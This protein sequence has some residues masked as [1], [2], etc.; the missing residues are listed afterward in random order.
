VIQANRYRLACSPALLAPGENLLPDLK[1]LRGAP[2]KLEQTKVLAMRSP[3]RRSARPAS[4]QSR[5]GKG[6]IQDRIQLAITD[7]IAD[8]RLNH[9]AKMNALDPAMF[10]AIAG[11]D[12]Q[13][14]DDRGLR[15]VVLSGEGR[16]FW[17][18]LISRESPRS[19]GA[20]ASCRS[21]ISPRAPTVSAIGPHT[22]PGCGAN[23]RARDRRGAWV[24]FG[25]SF[26]LALGA[27]LRYVAPGTLLSIMETKWGSVPEMAGTQRMRRLRVTTWSAN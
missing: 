11:S 2:V 12:A 14:K 22:S 20:A 16:A 3:A 23:A 13:F 17:P 1:R 25:R 21:R 10:R 24:A 18:V 9:A 15:A 7:G 8:V 5:E 6:G 19:L 26:Q 27:D 4:A